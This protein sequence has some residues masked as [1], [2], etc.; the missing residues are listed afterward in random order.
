MGETVKPGDIVYCKHC[1][2]MVVITRVEADVWGPDEY[3]VGVGLAKA[4]EQILRIYHFNAN[5][6]NERSFSVSEKDIVSNVDDITR[7]TLSRLMSI[8]KAIDRI[9]K[10]VEPGYDPYELGEG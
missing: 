9:R 4:G 1:R 7:D 3:E 5:Y 6:G 10:K 2:Q 8:E